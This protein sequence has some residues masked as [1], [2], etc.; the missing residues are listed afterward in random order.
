M[1]EEV[2]ICTCKSNEC[3]VF[4]N[5]IRTLSGIGPK[6]ALSIEKCRAA[7]IAVNVSI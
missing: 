7:E 5:A 4:N 6:N 3:S 2:R 1:M